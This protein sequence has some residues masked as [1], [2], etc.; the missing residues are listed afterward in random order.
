MLKN[1]SIRSLVL[2]CVGRV[3]VRKQYADV[4]MVVNKAIPGTIHTSMKIGKEHLNNH[5][6]GFG[7]KSRG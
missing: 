7:V 1:V 6:V 5:D 4:Q 3:P 2:S